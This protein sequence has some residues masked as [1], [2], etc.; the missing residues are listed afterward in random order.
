MKFRE[1]LTL[2]KLKIEPNFCQLIILNTCFCFLNQSLKSLDNTKFY[3]KLV[4]ILHN[5]V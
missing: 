4:K 3:N 1:K 2:L 5:K